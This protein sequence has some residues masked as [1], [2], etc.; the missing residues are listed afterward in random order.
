MPQCMLDCQFTATIILR[1][2]SMPRKWATHF[3]RHLAALSAYAYSPSS[4]SSCRHGNYGMMSMSRSIPTNLSC[5]VGPYLQHLP[6]TSSL[7]IRLLKLQDHCNS[8]DIELQLLSYRTYNFAH[9]IWLQTENNCVHCVSECL[10]Y[11]WNIKLCT[12]H[13]T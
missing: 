7:T 3:R 4:C 10:Y 5:S 12:I 13:K 8:H 1:H 6:T 11:I 2:H 9:K